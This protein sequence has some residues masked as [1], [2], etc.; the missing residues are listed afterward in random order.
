MKAVRG[1]KM[2]VLNLEQYRKKLGLSEDHWRA[3]W[4]N[5]ELLEAKLKAFDREWGEGL[6]EHGLREVRKQYRTKRI[7]A[8][9]GAPLFEPVSPVLAG[10]PLVAGR[11]KSIPQLNPMALSRGPDGFIPK[12]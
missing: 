5:P 7:K 1:A 4:R 8:V 12:D 2:T 11:G 10:K 3:V 6:T 9:R